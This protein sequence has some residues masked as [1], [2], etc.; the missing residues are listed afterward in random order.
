M[1]AML[2]AAG[3][4]RRLRPLTHHLP[5]PLVPVAGRPLITHQLEWLA[6][7]GV[8]EVVINLGH[9]GHLIE[10]Q[11]EDGH[12]WGLRIRYSRENPPLETGG[13]IVQA[14]PLL[15]EAPFMVMNSDLWTDFPLARLLQH[16]LPMD[17]TGHLVLVPAPEE[18]RGAG[19]FGLEQGRVRPPE[20]DAQPALFSGLSLLSPALFAGCR[21]GAAFPL[22]ELLVPAVSRGQ[23][24]G[25][26]HHGQWRDLGTPR[27]LA[28]LQQT[29]AKRGGAIR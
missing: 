9:L 12:R 18:Y 29:M 7:A 19:D 11:L 21:D 4:G 27:Q 25:E 23:I 20:P 13:G 17:Q 14:L 6:Q 26:V 5:K 3:H 16:H 24:G 1:K 22:R 8:R 28:M 15:G 2:L 10:Q